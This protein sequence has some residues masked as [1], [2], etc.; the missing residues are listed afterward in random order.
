MSLS[1]TIARRELRGGLKG[2]R[3]FLDGLA[4]ADLPRPVEIVPTDGLALHRA[5]DPTWAPP[6]PARAPSARAL[7]SIAQ[8]A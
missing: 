6:A 4:P 2:F 7:A 8:E 3:V 1:L 5:L